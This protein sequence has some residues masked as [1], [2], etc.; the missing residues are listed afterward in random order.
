MQ[1]KLTVPTDVQAVRY[2]G[3]VGGEIGTMFGEYKLAHLTGMPLWAAWTLPLLLSLYGYAAF[4]MGRTVDVAIA[5]GLVAVSQGVAHLITA[6]VVEVDWR[7][8]IAVW[9]FL[10]PI[11]LW[12]LHQ[13]AKPR[14][15]DVVEETEKS[16][17]EPTAQAAAQPTR[18]QWSLADGAAEIHRLETAHPGIR[19]TAI[20]AHMGISRVRVG[21]IKAEATAKQL[22]PRGARWVAKVPATA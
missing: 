6:F 10:V 2:L 12:R 21:Q 1:P 16:N 15:S 8:I 5:L 11:A 14:L 19:H 9:S 13:V 4:R 18:T 22:A 7:I 3:L 17:S 20:G